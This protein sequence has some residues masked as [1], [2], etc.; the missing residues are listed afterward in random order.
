MGGADL[1]PGRLRPVL[2]AG[3]GDLDVSLD[4]P[5]QPGSHPV[6]VLSLLRRAA[7]GIPR[8]NE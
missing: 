2:W 7:W 6:V 5:E 3:D 1:Q 4:L 8:L